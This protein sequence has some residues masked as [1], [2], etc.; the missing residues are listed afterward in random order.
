MNEDKWPP[1][2]KVLLLTKLR[3]NLARCVIEMVH[4]AKQPTRYLQLI[5][6]KHEIFLV[7]KEDQAFWWLFV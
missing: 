1:P 2:Y 4:G 6:L 7:V 5:M 3:V